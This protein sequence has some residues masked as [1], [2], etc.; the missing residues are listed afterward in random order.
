[1][2]VFHLILITGTYIDI[3]NKIILNFSRRRNEMNVGE[4][5]IYRNKMNE[6]CNYAGK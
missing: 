5:P 6:L 1:M 4:R 3:P 2:Q